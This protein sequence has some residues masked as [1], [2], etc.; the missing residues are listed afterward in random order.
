MG[1]ANIWQLAKNASI[2]ISPE[3]ICELNLWF[4]KRISS[5]TKNELINF[6]T[7]T[8]QN[9]SIPVPLS[10][11]FEYKHYLLT[12]D[13]KRVGY[14]FYWSEFTDYP[15]L[16]ESDNIPCIRLPVRTEK[17]TLE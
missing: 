1:N 17:W 5:V 2:N 14:L 3:I 15:N 4:D 11:D 6:I 10:I 9:F 16:N 12:R 7:W 8:E 13:K